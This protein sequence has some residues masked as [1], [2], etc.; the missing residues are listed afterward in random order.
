VL[1]DALNQFNE[2]QMSSFMLNCGNRK[3]ETATVAWGKKRH[4]ELE[5]HVFGADWGA[6]K[7]QRILASHPV[8]LQ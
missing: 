2:E 6:R 5:Q 4:M 8:K 3:I 7:L 1:I